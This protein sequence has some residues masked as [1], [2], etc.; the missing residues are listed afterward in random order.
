MRPL[1]LCQTLAWFLY[2]GRCSATNCDSSGG[3]AAREFSGCSGDA[4]VE[5]GGGATPRCCPSGFFCFSRSSAYC[6]PT[7][8]DCYDDVL[9]MPQC[10]HTGWSLWT[11][12]GDVTDGA[13]CCESDAF[14]VSISPHTNNGGGVACSPFGSTLDSYEE[15]ASLMMG[16]SLNC[17]SSDGVNGTGSGMTSVPTSSPSA[18][19][20]TTDSAQP[21]LSGSSSGA[22][23]TSSAP[24]P[25]ESGTHSESS[26]SGG[27]IAG[28]AIGGVIV[29]VL[30]S[31]LSWWIVRRRAKHRQVQTSH[32]QPTPAAEEHPKGFQA[33]ELDSHGVHETASNPI[34]EMGA[35]NIPLRR[36]EMEA[37]GPRQ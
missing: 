28:I 15:T 31:V 37:S 9:N 18:S 3:W 30:I 21:G 32:P 5:C 14:G 24:S 26:I 25:T 33:F 19:A 35:G 16:A 1:F 2:L 29:V 8:T 34:H 6:C 17:S 36:Y 27:A 12:D 11:N 13:W 10:P 23:Q 22:L 20:S 7:D 4:P